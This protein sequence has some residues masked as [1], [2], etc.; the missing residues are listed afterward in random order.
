[1]LAVLTADCLSVVIADGEGSVVGAAHAGWK[2]LAGGVLEAMVGQL[3]RKRQ[4]LDRSSACTWH[5][6][7]GPGIGAR[8]FQVG[9]DVRLAFGSDG[10]P[11]KAF[12]WWIRSSSASGVPT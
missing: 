1:V 10:D 11:G 4:M 9:E 8:A 2:G 7:I 12:L 5:A 3:L 6:W